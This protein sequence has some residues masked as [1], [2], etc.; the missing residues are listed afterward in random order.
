MG[1][2][3]ILLRPLKK[4]CRKALSK[5]VFHRDPL[6][7]HR[8]P[9]FLDLPTSASGTWPHSKTAEH[10]LI[11]GWLQ[12]VDTLAVAAVPRLGLGYPLE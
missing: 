9:L 1:V 4:H 7:A 11:F 8:P 10:G 2:A 6:D 5:S 3:K 12:V